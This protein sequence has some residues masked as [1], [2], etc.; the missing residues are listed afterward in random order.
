MCMCDCDSVCKHLVGRMSSYQISV[1]PTTLVSKNIYPGGYSL[2][3]LSLHVTDMLSLH[4]FTCCTHCSL[5]TLNDTTQ[6]SLEKSPVS[7]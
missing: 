6:M 7:G 1:D 2:P 4:G 3:C 5:S